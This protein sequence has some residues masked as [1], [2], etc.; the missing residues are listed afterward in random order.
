MK[1]KEFLEQTAILKGTDVKS[2]NDLFIIGVSGHYV[3]KQSPTGDIYTHFVGTRRL[4]LGLGDDIDSFHHLCFVKNIK[5][6]E[7][8]V[9]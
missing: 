2:M 3:H 6:I 5:E 1:L 9:I 7:D 8:Y 4:V